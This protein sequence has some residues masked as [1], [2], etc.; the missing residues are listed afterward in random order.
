[1]PKPI[2]REIGH[3]LNLKR[4]YDL[5]KNEMKQGNVPVV[6]SNGIIGFHNKYN[7][8]AP[9]ITVGRSGTVGIPQLYNENCWAHNTCLYID[10]FKGNN[11]E[12]LFY[13]LKTL[14]LD[15]VASSTGVPTLNRNFVHPLK[16]KYFE[17]VNVQKL[18]SKVL[19]QLDKKLE[20]NNKINSELEK[21]AKIF[22]TKIN[23]RINQA[24][25]KWFILKN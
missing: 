14:R 10:D 19:L 13:L 9:C 1:M 24:V 11:P 18:V 16:I 20:L 5:T 3:I 6:G 2:L 21:L 8:T 25:G 7:V 23:D 22:L 15:K 12:Y 4:G 17:E